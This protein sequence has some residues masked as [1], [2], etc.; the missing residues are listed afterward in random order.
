MA[1]GRVLA[2]LSAR[3][4][5]PAGNATALLRLRKVGNEGALQAGEGRDR[6]HGG[7][8]ARVPL[9]CVPLGCV[10]LGRGKRERGLDGGREH[11]RRRSGVEEARGPVARRE[12]LF[13][14]FPGEPSEVEVVSRRCGGVGGSAAG[15]RAPE[16]L[17]LAREQRHRRV[18]GGERAGRA[19]AQHSCVHES[20]FK[21]LSRDLIKNVLYVLTPRV[22]YNLLAG[23][24][25]H[26]ALDHFSGPPTRLDTMLSTASLAVVY[27][28]SQCSSQASAGL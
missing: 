2:R 25:R 6:V 23:V 8:A 18:T 24:E 20:L 19:A 21:F 5:A 4:R 11:P 3:A 9:G 1:G 10:P 15:R 13:L 17:P 22:G 26:P 16:V 12:R 7:P 14:A 27:A 28:L